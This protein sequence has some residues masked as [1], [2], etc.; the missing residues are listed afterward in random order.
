MRSAPV[1]ATGAIMKKF[2]NMC[3][4]EP[5]QHKFEISFSRTVYTITRKY[6]QLMNK[7]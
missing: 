2:I 4:E 3:N 7:N 1:A 5:L 6:E